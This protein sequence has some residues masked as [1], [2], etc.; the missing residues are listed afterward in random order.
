LNGRSNI[1]RKQLR[2][3]GNLGRL[4]TVGGSGKESSW[5][6]ISIADKTTQR[7][8]TGKACWD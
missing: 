4:E 1:D 5:A 8:N 6:G 2:G 7:K 3:K